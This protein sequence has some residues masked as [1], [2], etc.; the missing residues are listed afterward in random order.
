MSTKDSELPRWACPNCGKIFRGISEQSVD[1]KA[2]QHLE[3]C[4]AERQSTDPY[5]DKEDAKYSATITPPRDPDQYEMSEHFHSMLIRRENPEANSETIEKVLENGH[6]KSTHKSGRYIFEYEVDGWEWW[7]VVEMVDDALVEQEVNHI[8]VTIY[9][10]D[11][12]EHEKVVK[13]V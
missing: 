3:S 12:Q 11:S 7:I 2:E 10:P 8:A 5:A 6:I 4:D 13:Y 1:Q 9:S